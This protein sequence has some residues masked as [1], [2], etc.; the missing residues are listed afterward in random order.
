MEKLILN[1]LDKCGLAH[2]TFEEGAVELILRNADGLL[3]Q[4]RNIILGSLIQATIERKKTVN[5]SI[6][7]TVLIQPHWRSYEDL[8]KI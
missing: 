8:I 5:T 1:E 2:S 6:V 4:A 3:R 7:N